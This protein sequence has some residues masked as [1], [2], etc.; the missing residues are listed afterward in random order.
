MHTIQFNMGIL[1]EEMKKLREA[2][3]RYKSILIL[4]PFYT[5]AYLR[6]SFLA[7]KR[8][9]SVKALEY[10]KQAIDKI[11]QS[12]KIRPDLALCLKGYIFQEIGDTTNAR[13]SYESVKKKYGLEDPFADF[14]IM[15]ILYEESCEFRDQCSEQSLLNLRI[16]KEFVI[17]REIFEEFD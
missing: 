10:C 6:L 14:S 7:L 16:F 13:Q 5:D 2:N 15:R 4:N 12:K 9:S 1:F 8:G 3:E 11:E 17:F